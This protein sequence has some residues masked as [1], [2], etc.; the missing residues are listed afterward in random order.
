MK[1]Q[2]VGYLILI[3]LL[4]VAFDYMMSRFCVKFR[5]HKWVL[6]KLKEFGIW[7]LKLPLRGIR[8]GF[9]VLRDKIRNRQQ[10]KGEMKNV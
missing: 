5:L 10:E 3:V 6:K 8:A 1:E 7:I 4:I 2:I 9:K